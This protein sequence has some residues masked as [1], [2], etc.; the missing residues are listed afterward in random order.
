MA[1]P[2]LP[3]GLGLLLGGS[4]TWFA[5]R[6]PAAADAPA[7]RA[8]AGPA[9]LSA[10]SW[11]DSSAPPLLARDPAAS[12]VAAWFAL[13]GPD[14]RPASY[15][16]RAAS[17]RALLLQLP[18]DAFPRLLDG[19]SRSGADDD[20]RL[21]RIAFASWTTQ[22]APAATRWAFSQGEKSLS[23][24]SEAL[25]AW[26]AKDAPAAAAW[27]CALSDDKLAARFAGQALAA[28]ADKDPDRALALAR[29]RDDAFRASVLGSIL[30]TLGKT[31][32][33]GTLRTFAPELWKNGRGFY[34]LQSVIASWVKKDAP[35][36]IAWL[37]AQPRSDDGYG[38]VANWFTNLSDNSPASRRALADAIIA[39]PG[40]ANRA[41]IMRDVI[42]RW[43]SDH[44]ADF[45]A[46][47]SRLPDSDLRI[48]LLESASRVTYT[49]HPE[50]SLPIA[51]ALPEGANRSRRLAELLGSWTKL[52]SDAALDWM[53]KHAGEPGVNEAS[54]AMH[55]ALLGEIAKDDPQAA[56]KDLKDLTDPKARAA[57][58]DAIAKAWGARDPAAA[59]KWLSE[60]DGAGNRYY[61]GDNALLRRWA[62]TEPEAALRWI[63]ERVATDPAIKGNTPYFLDALAG[64]WS[65]KAPRAATA[66]LYSK[67]KDADLRVQT[68]SR[69][70]QEWLTKDPDGARAWVA[71]NPALTG[72]QRAKILAPAK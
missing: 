36:A 57:A 31:D 14:G 64:D 58:A 5:L 4:A 69:H 37:L 6:P 40:V 66:D 21:R 8:P 1:S 48:N 20:Q 22:D 33:A 50:Y 7:S 17:L 29:S 10:W 67:I 59:L 44:P 27:A 70:V 13:R 51:L 65:E 49:E 16:T 26:S 43:S 18:A 3:L 41:S 68:L 34:E 35:A 9:M 30:R 25:S 60:Q 46:W 47:I 15:A 32:P 53:Q 28:L 56:I 62:K 12:A 2:L 72:E 55:G 54:Y 45:G 19:L 23:L 71:A 11:R 24:T 63:E 39:A 52:N 38:N 61:G 42:L